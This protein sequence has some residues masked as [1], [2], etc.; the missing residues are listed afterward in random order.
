[1]ISLTPCGQK[2]LLSAISETTA[3]AF[4]VAG[5]RAGQPDPYAQAGKTRS[6]RRAGAARA[7][8]RQLISGATA[9]RELPG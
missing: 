8:A 5:S 3:V 2:K 6:P 9:W 1:M 4:T 7:P